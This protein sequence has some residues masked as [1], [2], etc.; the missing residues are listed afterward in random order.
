[1]VLDLN[2]LM[3]REMIEEEE[4]PI[5]SPQIEVETAD[6]R[7]GKFVIEPLEPGYGV[8]LGNPLR[9]V[10]YSGL[11]GTAITWVKIEG[12]QHEFATVPHVKEQVTEMLLNVKG[13]RLRSEVDRP[14][15]LRLEVAGEGEVCAGDIMASADFEVVNPELHLATLD[16]SEAKLSIE[17]NVERGKGYQV[18][19]E[20]DGQAIGV[21]PVDAIFTPINKVS[22]TIERTRVGQ[23][24]DF[25]R[26]VLQVWTDGSKLPV[27]AV[28]QAANILVTQFYMFANAKIDSQEGVDG[29]PQKYIVSAEIYNVTVERLDLPSRTL[30]CL[31]RAGIDKVG[32]VLEMSRAELMR[33]RNFGDKSYKELF[34]KLKEM[35]YLP[36]DMEPE[37][38]DDEET[39]AVAAE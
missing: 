25:E 19:A 5:P 31:K 16:S 24:T 28:R 37:T 26:L 12:I 34:G 33:I 21:L 38:A 30:N 4:E 20:G 22:Y 18:A 27:E 3:G 9:R 17:L 14:G 6:D 23:R 32:Q 15:K 39:E 7:Y 11:E 35:D 1:M 8:T 29:L 36:A 13:I 2:S 10:L